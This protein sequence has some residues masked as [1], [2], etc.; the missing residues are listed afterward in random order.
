MDAIKIYDYLTLARRRVFEWVRPL[1][2]E[3]YAR[4]FPIG[5]GTLGRTLTHIMICEWGYVQRIQHRAAARFD[6]RPFDD[7]APPAFAVLEDAWTKQAA[8]TRAALGAVRDW[9]E[10][11][12]FRVTWDDR[13]TIVTACAGDI[14]TQL[15]FHEVHHRAQAMNM[16]RQLGVSAE[17]I[18]YNALMYSRRDES[19]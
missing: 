3:Q 8:Q 16:L 5:L 17:D 1:S 15:A 6:Q 10:A 19:A 13:P 18:D 11:F 9:R 14:F 2:A 7:E 12:E 4:Q